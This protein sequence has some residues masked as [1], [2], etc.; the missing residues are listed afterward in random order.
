MEIEDHK[1]LTVDLNLLSSNELRDILDASLRRLDVIDA[2]IDSLSEESS[3]LS[4]KIDKVKMQL[5]VLDN[6]Q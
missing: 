3:D 1:G 6:I 2:K 5:D 4:W